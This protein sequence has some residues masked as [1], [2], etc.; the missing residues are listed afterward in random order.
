MTLEFSLNGTVLENP[1]DQNAATV[2]FRVFAQARNQ[3]DLLPN[4]FLRPCIDPIMQGF[5]GATFHLDLRTGFPAEYF[6]YF[7]TMLPQADLQHKI[8]LSD[9]PEV[10]IAPPSLENTKVY[11]DQ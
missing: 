10:N 5:P 8:H 11:A 1:L 3:S 9:G 6:E 4:K 7:V 2:D